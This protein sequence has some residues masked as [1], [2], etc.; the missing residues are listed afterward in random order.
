[1]P[2]PLSRVASAAALGLLAVTNVSEAQ[3]APRTLPTPEVSFGEPF[4]SVGVGAIREL[5]DGRVLVA[6]PRDKVLSLVDFRAGS[7]TPVGREGSGPQEFGMPMRLFAAPGDTTLLYDPLNSR[8]LIVGADGKPINTFRTENDP[9]GG[10]RPGPP[11]GPPPG[12]QPQRGT[13]G[14]RPQGG[15]ALIGGGLIARVSDAQGRLYGE[16]VGFSIGENGQPQ[17]PDSAAIVRFDRATRKVDTLAYINL[18]KANTQVSGSGGN[19]SFRIGGANPLLP[20]DEWTVF[21][22]GMLAIVR[23]ADYHVEWVMPNGRKTSSSPIRY[24]PVRMNAA[25]IRHEEE[26]RNRARANQMSIAVTNDG[27]GTRRSA[28]MGPPPGAPPLEP[29]TD[30]PEVKP[31]FRS[32]AASVL[33]RPN[34][35]LWVRRTET[36]SVK[37][38]LYDVI[39]NQGAVTHQIRVPDGMT[40]VGFGNGTIYTT[41]LDEDDLVYL[42]RHRM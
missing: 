39:N 28:Q 6:D 10:T 3:Q 19:V 16:S 29:L 34:G 40:L 31:P 13:P 7:S 14:P 32:G 33:A 18:P 1:M 25:E 21:P 4:S 11:P 23:A 36:S 17:Q 22:D 42:Q 24:T 41:K 35:E 15:P 37:G 20:R 27:A 26:L 12:A 9:A 5:R 38:T 8:Y 30:W 2:L